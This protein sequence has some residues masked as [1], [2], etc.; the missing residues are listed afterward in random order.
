MSINIDLVMAY[1]D[2]IGVDAA[3]QKIHSYD[4]SGPSAEDFFGK[5]SVNEL[6][7]EIEYLKIPMPIS[8]TSSNNS[9]RYGG[10]N[11]PISI[12]VKSYTNSIGSDLENIHQSG[13]S[14][15]VE[16][17]QS[18]YSTSEFANDNIEICDTDY[19]SDAA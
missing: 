7:L 6:D 10:N 19:F 5:T 11:E 17:Y 2:S 4:V 16:T 14:L 3:R 12:S 15:Y 1:I 13:S 9:Y 18:T 8:E